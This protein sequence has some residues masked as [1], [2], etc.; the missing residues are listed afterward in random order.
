MINN[1]L[2]WFQ[3]LFV[4]TNEAFEFMTSNPFNSVPGLETFS[5]LALIGIGGLVAFIGIALVKWVIS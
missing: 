5:P 3:N 1:L 4:G 2:L